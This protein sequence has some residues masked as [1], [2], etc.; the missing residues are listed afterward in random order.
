[1]ESSTRKIKDLGPL[2]DL[3]IKACPPD[4]KGNKSIPL[5]AKALNTS[6]QN[7]YKC[8]DQNRI[9]TAHQLPK[10]IIEISDGRVSQEDLIPFLNIM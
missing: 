6:M 2:H 7:L 3:L 1:M 8:I 5:L 9:P 10:R 4:N